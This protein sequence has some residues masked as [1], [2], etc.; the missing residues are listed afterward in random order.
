M[1]RIPNK[2]IKNKTIEKPKYT[3]KQLFNFYLW[4]W[5]S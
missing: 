5:L 1:K 4:Q 2:K 3:L